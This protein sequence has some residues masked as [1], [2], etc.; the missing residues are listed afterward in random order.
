METTFALVRYSPAWCIFMLGLIVA[1]VATFA[2][3]FAIG[4]LVSMQVIPA[5]CFYSGVEEC[6]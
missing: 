6:V 1:L 4:E 3:F 2:A 5:D